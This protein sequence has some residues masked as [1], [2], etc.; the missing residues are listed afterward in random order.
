MT[1]PRVLVLRCA[2]INCNDE[3]AFAFEIAGAETE[4]VHVNRI[5][6]APSLLGRFGAIAIPG[7]FSYGDD[8]AAGKILA[9]ELAVAL[10]DALRAFVDKG[11]LII[12]IC[13]GFQALVKTGLLPG[14]VAG[15]PVVAT[16]SWNE[17]RRYEDRWV[18]VRANAS[19]CVFIWVDKDFAMM[20]GWIQGFPKKLGA[21]H[22]TRVF[23]VGRATPRVGPG[24][25]FGAT[26]TAGSREIA[27]AI[28]TLRR[29]SE[30]GPTVN[31]P[32]MHNTR[33]FPAYS[34]LAPAV[35]ELVRAGGRDRS[36]SEIWE[37]DAELTFGSNTPGL[38][39]YVLAFAAGNFLYVAMA[40]LIPSLHRGNLDRN[41]PRQVILIVMGVA[42]IA[43]L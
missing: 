3:T 20:R 18:R 15:R 17:S 38:V 2:G 22:M 28:V 23:P 4:Q 5:R 27:R 33:L 1:R 24:E 13:N 41:S 35:F 34:G 11:G 7:G 6:E 25:R 12:G 30:R 8:V 32:P 21:I 14:A 36:I 9:I 10:G 31:D 29:K 40:D 42:T 19:R 39:P 37:G 43:M 26:C 16:L